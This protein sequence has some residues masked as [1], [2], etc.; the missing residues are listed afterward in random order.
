MF[1]GSILTA[2]QINELLD[3]ASFLRAEQTECSDIMELVFIDELYNEIRLKCANGDIGG[4]YR[5]N[6]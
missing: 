6:V 1:N 4:L 5:A 2:R 3:G